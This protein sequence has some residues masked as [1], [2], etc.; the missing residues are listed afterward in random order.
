MKTFKIILLA[1]CFILLSCNKEESKYQKLIKDKIECMGMERPSDS[2]NYPLYPGMP[3]WASLKTSQEMIDACK[4][5][6]ELLQKKSTQAVIQAI[7]EYPFFEE[8]FIFYSNFSWDF[9]QHD[10]Y[11]ELCNR[12]D[13]GISIFKRLK[14]YDMKWCDKC[15]LY[16]EPNALEILMSQ[17]QFLSQLSV[18]EKKELIK[19][20]LEKD[21]QH[22][23]SNYYRVTSWLLIGRILLNANYQP[24]IN[25]VNCNN[26]LKKFVENYDYFIYYRDNTKELDKMAQIIKSYTINFLK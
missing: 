5:P 8:I 20:T 24:F 7:W 25:E 15:P 6:S 23:T 17:Y 1:I 21:E 2:Y 19:K 22:I 10:A 14:M 3:E 4:I 26:T 11:L 13:A 18:S 16:P 9:V 12:K